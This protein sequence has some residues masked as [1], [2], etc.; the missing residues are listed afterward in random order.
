MNSSIKSNEPVQCFLHQEQGEMYHL[1]SFVFWLLSHLA[2]FLTT[3]LYPT[4]ALQSP[5]KTWIC[6]FSS[7]FPCAWLF[8]TSP[9]ALSFLLL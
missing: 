2:S 3:A 4:N 6:L 8:P 5:L 9:Q 7:P 1:F